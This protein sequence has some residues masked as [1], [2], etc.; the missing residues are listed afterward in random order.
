MGV[1]RDPVRQW[2]GNPMRLRP[3]HFATLLALAAQQRDESVRVEAELRAWLERQ[4]RNN[5]DRT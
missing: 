1:P 5:G 3:H 2:L 4:P